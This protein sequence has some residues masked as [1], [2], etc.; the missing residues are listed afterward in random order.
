MEYAF[1]DLPDLS[2][3]NARA[4]GPASLESYSWPIDK[5]L[6]LAIPHE[7][8][9]TVLEDIFYSPE[10]LWTKQKTKSRIAQLLIYTIDSWFDATAR[11]QGIAFGSDENAVKMLELVKEVLGYLD[12]TRTREGK[13]EAERVREKVERV[14]W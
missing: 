12:S 3:N 11:A 7:S 5:M 8:L 2:S 1:K 13:D 9:V 4:T 10:A 14:L 6:D